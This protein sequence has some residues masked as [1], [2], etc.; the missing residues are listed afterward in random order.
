MHK[1][2]QQ[3]Y[4]SSLLAQSRK[5]YVQNTPLDITQ[6]KEEIELLEI[7][8]QMQ[9]ANIDHL[10]QI[11]NILNALNKATIEE[12]DIILN[13]R[14]EE[15]SKIQEIVDP[16]MFPMFSLIETLDIED[17]VSIWDYKYE[18]IM[19][20]VKLRTGF[21]LK[22]QE[23]T[24]EHHQAGKGV[25]LECEKEVTIGTLL[26]F[27]GGII[28]NDIKDFQ[29]FNQKESLN[30]IFNNQNYIHGMGVF[31]IKN[32]QNGEELFADYIESESYQANSQ[33][34]DWLI[35]SDSNIEF[36]KQNMENN[37][38]KGF[39]ILEYILSFQNMDVLEDF[40][41]KISKNQKEEFLEVEKKHQYFKLKKPNI[42]LSDMTEDM[43]NDASNIVLASIDK[44]TNERDI[45]YYIKKEFDKRHLGQWHVVV[46]KQFSSY[47]THEEGYFILLN[48][49]PLQVL[50]FRC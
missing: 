8:E 25:F 36:L 49:G 35:K 12:S 4:I 5:Y 15:L 6:A 10:E 43:Q 46:G 34:L 18:K 11:F 32:I 9:Y 50:I 3:A 21:L 42:K 20:N 38:G 41:N 31:A 45:S 28:F 24:I 30:S 40:E 7:N 16:D 33:H 29:N 22:V 26:G 37:Y 44:Y 19:P 47:V 27:M 17:L 1:Y 2:E 39:K 48:K 14:Y 23:S 13:R